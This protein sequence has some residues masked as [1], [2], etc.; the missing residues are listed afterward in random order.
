MRPVFAHGQLR[1]YMLMLLERRPLHG[2]EVIRELQTLFGG[3]YSPSAG[4][5]YPRLAK[6]QK[7][8][9]VE[10]ADEGRKSTYRL[11][12][13]GRAELDARRAEATALE[14]SLQ[15]AARRLAQETRRPAEGTDRRDADPPGHPRGSA[16][17]GPRGG[18][19]SSGPPGAASS[20]GA[21][22]S[23]RATE[24]LL[25]RLVGDLVED[26]DSFR[27][28]ARTLGKVGFEG[29]PNRG[30]AGAAGAAAAWAT[31][32]AACG[33]ADPA[34]PRSRPAP[35]LHASVTALGEP[36]GAGGVPS[37]EQLADIAA[38]LYDAYFRIRT[39]LEE[40]R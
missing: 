36:R 8:G 12:A 4:T 14:K 10:R 33:P 11:T 35:G 6:L 3:L 31:I 25:L 32:V 16:D 34:G 24:A 26:P 38:I 22:W 1:L 5:V 21:P 19:A 30:V 27:R 39:V 29:H 7:V 15:A 37:A 17:G 20:A 28:L 40:T 23:A 2:Y 9:L 18:P 13:A